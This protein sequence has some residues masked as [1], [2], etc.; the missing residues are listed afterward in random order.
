MRERQT[1]A[2]Q[3][4]YKTFTDRLKYLHTHEASDKKWR[5]YFTEIEPL[6]RKRDYEVDIRRTSKNGTDQLERYEDIQKK[7]VGLGYTQFMVASHATGSS[8]SAKRQ[9]KTV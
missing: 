7:A 2:C 8:S 1:Q 6:L 4:S 5:R 9:R 3:V